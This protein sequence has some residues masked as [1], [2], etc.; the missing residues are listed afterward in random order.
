M[1]LRRVRGDP[2]AVEVGVA[3]AAVDRHAV[4]AVGH[5]RRGV[6]GGDDRQPARAQ[7]L[8]HRAAQ[9]LPDEVVHDPVVERRFRAVP[10]RVEG[11][12]L[13]QAV[14]HGEHR[15]AHDRHALGAR[16]ELV[17]PAEAAPQARLVLVRHAGTAGG[18]DALV[19]EVGEGVR[20]ALVAQP[21]VGGHD[22]GAELV[23]GHVGISGQRPGVLPGRAAAGGGT[24]AAQDT[25]AGR[26]ARPPAWRRHGTCC[27]LV[28]AAAHPRGVVARP[29][30]GAGSHVG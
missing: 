5:Q 27:I 25:P 21:H 7:P 12:D 9:P 23:G 29:W 16:D 24:S 19:R 15:V 4:G 22:P 30:E 17:G 13:Q 20:R 2:H 3:D 10:Q 18:E 26:G 8:E 1:A 28:R 11:R 14:Q 6:E